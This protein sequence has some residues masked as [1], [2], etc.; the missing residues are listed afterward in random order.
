MW[1]RGNQVGVQSKPL[2]GG[3]ISW[4]CCFGGQTDID[5][6]KGHKSARRARTR[7]CYPGHQSWNGSRGVVEWDGEGRACLSPFSTLDHLIQ[8]ARPEPCLPC[9]RARFVLQPGACA[10]LHLLP[11]C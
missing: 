9:M 3:L 5:G 7:R 1:K 2:T 8:S 4:S 6:G 11:Y 10:L